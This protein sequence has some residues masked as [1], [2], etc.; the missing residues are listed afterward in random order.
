MFC[1]CFAAWIA[2]LENLTTRVAFKE[3]IEKKTHLEIIRSNC[4]SGKDHGDWL[5][6]LAVLCEDG[7]ESADE[8][9]F[10]PRFWDVTVGSP[11]L[12]DGSEM[13]PLQMS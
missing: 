1:N 6:S 7:L 8:I 4:K 11:A 2:Y 5:E 12:S 3:E 13:R 9:N 10:V